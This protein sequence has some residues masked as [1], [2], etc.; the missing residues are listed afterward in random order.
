MEFIS[1][2]IFDTEQDA[3]YHC[4]LCTE[5]YSPLP[6]GWVWVQYFVEKSNGTSIIFI[7]FD[8]SLTPILVPLLGEPIE[9][10]IDDLQTIGR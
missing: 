2:W 7:I 1:G 10:Q 5:Y 3:Q 6:E 4:D 9:I 8:E